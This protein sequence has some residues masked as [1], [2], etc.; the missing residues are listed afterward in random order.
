MRDKR[1]RAMGTGNHAGR[2]GRR[3]HSAQRHVSGFLRAAWKLIVLVV[4]AHPDDA[5]LGAGG[6]IAKLVKAGFRVRVVILTRGERGGNARARVRESTRALALLGVQKKDIIWGPFHDTRVPHD[7]RAIAYLERFYSPD[8]H[9]VLTH[10][11]NDKH[12][13]HYAAARACIT[14]FR[15]VPCLLF[16][17]SPSATPEFAPRFFLD[18]TG[19]LE[20]KAAALACHKSQIKK[21][22]SLEYNS[23]VQLAA[24][25]GHQAGVAHAEAFEV[26]RFVMTMPLLTLAHST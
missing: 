15:R 13:D 1:E 5:E 22:M 19:E 25:R 18:I 14:A 23:M 20:T 7:H 26:H 17:E 21:C 12:Q 4:A 2:R 16:F 3:G 8:V 6:S 9:L 11:L 24:F 10:S